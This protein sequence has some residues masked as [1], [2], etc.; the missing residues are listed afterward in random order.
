MNTE[1]EGEKSSLINHRQNIIRFRGKRLELE[2]LCSCSLKQIYRTSSSAGFLDV[3]H[4]CWKR[5]CAEVTSRSVQQTPVS[6]GPRASL[7][8]YTNSLDPFIFQGISEMANLWSKVASLLT[9]HGLSAWEWACNNTSSGGEGC[10]AGFSP[11][12]S[13]QRSVCSFLNVYASLLTSFRNV[14]T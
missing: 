12:C 9:A 8:S 6:G 3:Q 10:S 11:C 14:W 5:E 7:H 2:G 1:K 4:S 13:L